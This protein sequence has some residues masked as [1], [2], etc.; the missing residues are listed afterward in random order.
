MEAVVR[1][2]H[3]TSVREGGRMAR[4][5]AHE[6]CTCLFVS[7]PLSSLCDVRAAVVR[8]H[9]AA[10][11]PHRVAN[12]HVLGRLAMTHGRSSG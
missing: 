3:E 1:H 9:R 11:A 6:A 5:G 7:L 10:G 12:T 8:V 2:A 4:E